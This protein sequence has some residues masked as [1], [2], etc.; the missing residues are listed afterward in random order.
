MTYEKQYSHKQR[1]NATNE[2]VNRKTSRINTERDTH[3][4]Q[5]SQNCVNIIIIKLTLTVESAL[6][7]TNIFPFSS[8]ALVND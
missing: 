5:D 3:T 1:D 8:I 2:S 6:P 7:D 4:E